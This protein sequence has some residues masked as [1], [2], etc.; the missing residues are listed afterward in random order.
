M[1]LLKV[2]N[3]L[4][5]E[6]HGIITD[7]MLNKNTSHKIAWASAMVTYKIHMEKEKYLCFSMFKHSFINL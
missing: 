1:Q 5:S 6:V 4:V 3:R 2:I 7:V